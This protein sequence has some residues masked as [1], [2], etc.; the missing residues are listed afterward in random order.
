MWGWT[1]NTTDR[2]YKRYRFGAQ[3]H[4]GQWN[5][6]QLANAIYPLVGEVEPLQE[7]LE[8]YVDTFNH[9]WPRMM[10]AKLGIAEFDAY[11]E[12]EASWNPGND[13][14][15]MFTDGLSE[16]IRADRIWSDDLI[17]DCIRR[18]DGSSALEILDELFTIASAT[19][20]QLADDRTALILK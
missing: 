15:L 13:T 14:L 12:R 11:E 1:P 5:C 18:K 17:L 7:A 4:I 9:D 6:T 8:V 16:T 2:E 19:P 3:P 10:A 20:A